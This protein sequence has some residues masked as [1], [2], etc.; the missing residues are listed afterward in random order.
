MR[1]LAFEYV[2][3]L[4]GEPTEATIDPGKP[5]RGWDPGDPG[6]VDAPYVCQCGAEISQDELWR[7]GEVALAE[8]AQDAAEARAE[9]QWEDRYGR[10]RD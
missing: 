6:E 7:Q 4:C 3:P 5:A 1:P 9:A 8:A 10:S 2:C